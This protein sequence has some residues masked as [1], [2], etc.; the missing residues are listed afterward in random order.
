MSEYK[1]F[2]KA[3]EFACKCCG[4][5]GIKDE[6]W[7]KLEA[8]RG[9]AGIPFTINSGFRCTNN[10]NDLIA[11]GLSL[12]TSSHPKGLAA[13]IKVVASGDR[14]DVIKALIK[15]GINRIGINKTFIHAD[16][17]PDK[18]TNMVW[19]YDD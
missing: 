18:P 10:Q 14:F 19:L 1:S 2:F 17:D 11:R 9:I 13:D 16:I 4:K 7:K 8:A 15:A 6:L 12:P 3:S 5:G